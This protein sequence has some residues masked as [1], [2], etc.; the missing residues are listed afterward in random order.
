MTRAE[1][2]TPAE[3]PADTLGSEFEQSE[4][5]QSLRDELSALLADEEPVGS[6]SEEEA[7]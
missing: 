3:L 5:E 2:R 6:H 4:R 7:R 1:L